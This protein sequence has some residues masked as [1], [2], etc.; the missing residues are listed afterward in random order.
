M[1]SILAAS[2]TRPEITGDSIGRRVD[3]TLGRKAAVRDGIDRYGFP[4]TDLT[5]TLD[6]L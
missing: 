1:V 2:L 3:E 6:T 4:R 5:I